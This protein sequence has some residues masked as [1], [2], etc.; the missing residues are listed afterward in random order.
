MGSSCGR[1]AFFVE[2][3]PEAGT[4]RPAL[5]TRRK[6]QSQQPH[7]PQ[8]RKP[9]YTVTSERK[10]SAIEV[11][12]KHS[13][14]RLGV[15]APMTDKTRYQVRSV[16]V[17][18]GN[19]IEPTNVQAGGHSCPIRF[20]CAGCGFYRPDPSYLPAIEEHLNSLKADRGT[21]QALG[22]ADFV[23]DNIGAQVSA[24]EK[25]LSHL[26]SSLDELDPVERQRVQEASATLRKVR[27]VDDPDRL[28]ITRERPATM[29]TFGGGIHYC[30]G[31]HLAR[32]ELA[33]AL[34]VITRRMPNPRRSGPAPWKP[35]MG[36]TGPTTLPIEFD[37]GH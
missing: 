34:T 19:C 21:A 37:A 8:V 1:T 10:R 9:Q 36:I 23:V 7:A 4:P 28:D 29:L 3:D 24:Y 33:E 13:I 27:A 16:A 2:T 17:P 15:P 35:L 20:Q 32:A 6:L 14:D 12:G 18:F 30:L 31:A 11:V 26:R 22:V 25:V 5:T